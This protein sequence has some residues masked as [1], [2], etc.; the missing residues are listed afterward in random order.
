MTLVIS[1]DIYT[2]TYRG[3]NEWRLQI[4]ELTDRSTQHLENHPYV[5]PYTDQIEFYTG[6]VITV[7]SEDINHP[8]ADDASMGEWI[9]TPDNPLE[10]IFLHRDAE[11][12][13]YPAQAGPVADAL[14]LL[15]PH[16]DPEEEVSNHGYIVD[17]T[18]RFI[19]GL[20]RAAKSNE[21]VVF[22]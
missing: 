19:A 3:F 9:Q 12:Y 21:R 13:I 6:T 15:L 5:S 18:K 16:M 2:G 7:D 4:A 8:Y 10:V 17:M 1:H 22:A 14:E 20:R 11:G